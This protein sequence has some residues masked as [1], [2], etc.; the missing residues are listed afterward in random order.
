LHPSVLPVIAKNGFSV[1]DL[2]EI[3]KELF[4]KEID[5]GWAEFLNG[6]ESD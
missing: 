5:L 3:E 2:P 6:A 1:A 4:I